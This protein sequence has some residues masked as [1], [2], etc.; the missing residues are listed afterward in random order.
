MTELVMHG[1]TDELV[2]VCFWSSII[3][4]RTRRRTSI[5]HYRLIHTEQTV[6]LGLLYRQLGRERN[7]L[8]GRLIESWSW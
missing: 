4:Y 5:L 8:L 7:L 3:W 6:W 1:V 2:L